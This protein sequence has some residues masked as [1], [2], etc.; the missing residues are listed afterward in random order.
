MRKV[1]AKITMWLFNKEKTQVFHHLNMRLYH[2]I[3]T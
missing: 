2:F 3:Y 1:D